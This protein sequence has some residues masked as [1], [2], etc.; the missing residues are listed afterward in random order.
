MMQTEE[1]N[2][3]AEMP[4]IVPAGR[5]AQTRGENRAESDLFTAAKIR[6]THGSH[7]A[8]MAARKSNTH[9]ETTKKKN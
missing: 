7:S 3:P 2:P 8:T 4:L 6:T 5:D 9:P 1:L